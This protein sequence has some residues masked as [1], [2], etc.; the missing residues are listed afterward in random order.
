VRFVVPADLARPTGGNRYDRALA[1]ALTGLGVDVELVEVAG[2]WPDAS[3]SAH[4]ELADRLLS[5]DPVLVD[6]LL[7]CGSPAAVARAV[8]RGSSVH[9][10]V[11]MPLGVDPG[12]TARTAADR[13]ARE[14][15]T[16]QAAGGVLTTSAW[17]AAE[18]RR[19]HGVVA[20]TVATP[21]TD[22]AAPAHGSSPPLLRQLAT[23]SPVKDQ[24]TV[25]AALS[26]LQ[27]LAWTAELTGSLDVDPRYTARVR[28]AI[29]AA[30][31]RER[32]HLTGPLTD[33]AL[34][35]AWDATDLLLLPS[36]AET[37]GLV[38]TEALSRGIPAVVGRGTGAVEALGSGPD[39]VLPGA[40]V[41]PGDPRSLAGA[42][43]QLLGP[44]RDDVRRAAGAR[45]AGLPGWRTTA[46]VVRTALT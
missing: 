9:V 4:E 29:D 20:L 28:E 12:L 11:H 27:D 30:G 35:R 2:T 43:R 41:P 13:D 45:G 39:G 38:V 19:R 5:R 7:A 44:G 10:L 22:R 34:E 21:G 31:L 16:L 18:L 23:I 26:G 3:A 40:V 14:R 25:V 32:V 8:V 17:A 37:W 1:D 36:R 15:A 46:S 42:V 6:G 24:C 33:G